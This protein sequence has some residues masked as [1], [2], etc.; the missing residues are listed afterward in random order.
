M[1]GYGSTQMGNASEEQTIVALSLEWLTENLPSP[2]VIKCDVEG[3]ELEIFERTSKML[4][5][6]RPVIICEVRSNT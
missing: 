3:A 1:A 5:T 6:L 4:R 2:N